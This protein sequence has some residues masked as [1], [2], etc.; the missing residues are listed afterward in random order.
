MD[1]NLPGQLH[2][3][4][5]LQDLVVTILLAGLGEFLSKMRGNDPVELKHGREDRMNNGV[6]VIGFILGIGVDNDPYPFG[7][8]WMT[9]CI[10]I[11]LRRQPFH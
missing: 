10:S 6:L 5:Y 8:V 11:T 4:Q 3:I 2:E 1:R 7:G 9:T